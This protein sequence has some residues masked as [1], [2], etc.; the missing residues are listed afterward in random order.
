MAGKGLD[1]RYPVM[2]LELLGSNISP[3]SNLH[4]PLAF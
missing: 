1:R 4:I 3:V 2:V